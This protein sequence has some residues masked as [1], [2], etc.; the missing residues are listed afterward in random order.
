[1]NSLEGLLDERREVPGNFLNELYKWALECTFM[2]IN[3]HTLIMILKCEPFTLNFIMFF[4]YLYTQGM[5]TF[6]I[7]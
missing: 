1:M 7:L 4:F 2:K 5:K 3:Y 6:L